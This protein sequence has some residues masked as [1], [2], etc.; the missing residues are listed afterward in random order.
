MNVCDWHELTATQVRSAGG[1]GDDLLIDVAAVYGESLHPGDEPNY[2]SQ[3]SQASIDWSEDGTRFSIACSYRRPR[4][5]EA[6]Q[7]TP[8]PLNASGP[9]GVLESAVQLYFALC[10]S[11]FDGNKDGIAKFGYD[12]PATN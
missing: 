1:D 11:Y 6:G 8:L 2:P 12:V 10:H 9:P 3:A 7:E 4:F 5:I